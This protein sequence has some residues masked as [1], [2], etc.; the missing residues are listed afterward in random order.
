MAMLKAFSN[1]SGVSIPSI[2]KSVGVWTCRKCGYTFAGGAY[3]PF[4]KIGTIAKRAATSAMS[5]IE[6]TTLTIPEESEEKQ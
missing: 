1:S 3:T 2:C 6:R 5:S 4:T